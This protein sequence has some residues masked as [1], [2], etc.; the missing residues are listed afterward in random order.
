MMTIRK[1]INSMEEQTILSDRL[2]DELKVV[3]WARA[4]QIKLQ[5]EKSERITKELAEELTLFIRNSQNH[6]SDKD[7]DIPTRA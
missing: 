4:E 2:E 5:K 7:A 3:E 6:L 1:G